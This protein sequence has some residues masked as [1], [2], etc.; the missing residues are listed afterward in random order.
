MDQLRPHGQSPKT[1][2][3]ITKKLFEFGKSVRDREAKQQ[4]DE[5]L[6]HLR[7]L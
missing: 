5:I 6:D 1:A 2:G 3:E 7:E 4:V